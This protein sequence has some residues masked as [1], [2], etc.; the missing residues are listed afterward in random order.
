[1]NIVRTAYFIERLINFDMRICCYFNRHVEKKRI[2][3]FFSTISRLGDG[4]FW[5]ALILLIP[6]IFGPESVHVSLRMAGAGLSGLLLYKLIKTLTERQRPFIKSN[7]I[8]LG[9]APLDQY[10]F[11]SGHTLHAVSFS[12]VAIHYFPVL[13]WLLVP[14]ATLIAMSRVVLGLHFPTDVLAGALIGF[15]LALMFVS[16]L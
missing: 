1:M 12:L 5:Y 14:L 3:H 9:A 16:I 4:P 8:V 6:F 11:P 10:S 2:R 13:A 15:G 7:S